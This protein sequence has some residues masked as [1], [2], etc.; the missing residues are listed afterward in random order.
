MDV[1]TVI[2]TLDVEEIEKLGFSEE[3][4]DVNGEFINKDWL[5]DAL[6]GLIADK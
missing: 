5:T 1:V 6:H 4:Y 3:D 2:I